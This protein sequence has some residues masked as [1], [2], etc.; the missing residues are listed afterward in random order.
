MNIYADG[1]L[2]TLKNAFDEKIDLYSNKLDFNLNEIDLDIPRIQNLATFVHPDFKDGFERAKNIVEYYDQIK[3]D[4]VLIKSNK[5]LKYILDNKK[6]GVF[7]SIENGRAI[8][9]NIQNVDWFYEKGIRI[10]GL[11]WNEDNLIG[12]G[13]L[14]ENDTG[15]TKFGKE[16]VKKLEEKNILIDVSH[17]SEKT[18]WDTISNTKKTIIATHSCSYD[19]CNHP[20]NLKDDQIKAIAERGG[21]IGVCFVNKFLNSDIDNASVLDIVKHIEYIINLVG[22]DYVGL[23]SD[24]D[25]LGDDFKLK[26]VSNVGNVNLIENELIKKGYSVNLIDKIMGYNWIRVFKENL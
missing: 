5:E 26:D 20:R 23:G 18:F 13:S 8:G 10:M 4:T 25:G 9:D 7:L 19:L 17:A 14:T 24:F 21:I 11:T 1:H 16:Y 6:M 2:D 15:L 22:E 3:G 12:C